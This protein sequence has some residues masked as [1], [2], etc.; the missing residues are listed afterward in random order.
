MCCY[1]WKC[2]EH[3]SCIQYEDENLFGNKLFH[4][5]DCFLFKR[6]AA[7]VKDVYTQDEFR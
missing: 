2:S 1:S 4:S 7:F 3:N 6:L 5:L